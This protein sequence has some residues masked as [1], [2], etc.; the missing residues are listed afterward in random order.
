[1]ENLAKE[2]PTDNVALLSGKT[3]LIVDDNKIN[4]LVTQK[5]LDLLSMKYS[6][7]GDGKQ[8]ITM[9][10]HNTYDLF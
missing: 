8:A 7:A 3:V 2:V 4:Q 9:A 10:Q 5:V 6:T 1:M